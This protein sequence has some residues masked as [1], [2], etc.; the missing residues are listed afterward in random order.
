[1]KWVLSL[2]LVLLAV[3]TLRVLGCGDEGTGP[4]VI[5]MGG[6]DCDDGN[7]CTEDVCDPANASCTNPKRADG[8]AC[9]V[10]GLPGQCVDGVCKG[11]CAGASCEDNTSVQ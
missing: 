9:M 11:L 7:D 4:S 6:E 5:C 3:G 2:V 1:M 8:A 10:D